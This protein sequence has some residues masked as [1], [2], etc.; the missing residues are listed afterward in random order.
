MKITH[1][2]LNN[3]EVVICSITLFLLVVSYAFILRSNKR[4]Q[5]ASLKI[6]VQAA[7]VQLAKNQKDVLGATRSS[8]SVDLGANKDLLEANSNFS[9]LIQNLSGDG[10]LYRVN[11][12][13]L[14]SAEEKQ[15][16]SKNTFSLE[17]ET[18]FSNL[19]QF[20]EK[21]E[22]SNFLVEI[23]QIEVSRLS[24]ELRQCVAKIQINS[25]VARKEL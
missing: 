13:S 16:L 6:E 10:S 24:K 25:Y 19:G 8:A 2:K 22:A 23:S 1:G 18:S 15:G 5:I 17:I 21:L 9:N 7:Q 14:D 4:E 20:I 12:L 3:R 11:R